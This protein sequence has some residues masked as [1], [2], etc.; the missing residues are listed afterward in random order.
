[1]DGRLRQGA[2][3]CGK[4]RL[5]GGARHFPYGS[6][7]VVDT[8]T[9][10]FDTSSPCQ[11]PSGPSLSGRHQAPG[12]LRMPRGALE[13][14]MEIAAYF[15][16]NIV[17]TRHL[18]TSTR[19]EYRVVCAKSSRFFCSKDHLAAAGVHPKKLSGGSFWGRRSVWEQDRDC[20][21]AREQQ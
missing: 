21:Q 2:A 18:A 8:E 1:M 15:G 19:F 14:W 3:K 20:A 11:E 5:S 13:S 4:V 10:R 17:V 9:R 16:H 12:S 6:D 7:P